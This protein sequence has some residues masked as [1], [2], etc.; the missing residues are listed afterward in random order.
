MKK[1]VIFGI[2]G[3]IGSYI[4]EML[5]ER[6]Y[7]VYGIIRR[8]SSFNTPRIDHIF[9]KLHLYYGDITDYISIDKVL[10]EVKPDYI[11]NMA[12]QSHVWISFFQPLYTSQVDGIGPL[13]ILESMKVNCPKAKYVQAST[14]ELYG[15]LRNPGQAQTEDE[16]LFNPISPYAAAKLYGYYITK[17]YRESYGL[18]ACNSICFNNEGPRRGG[19]FVTKKITESLVKISSGKQKVL[20]LGNIDSLRDWGY[21]KEYA[22]GIIKIIENEYP[23]DYVLATNETHSIREFV[24]EAARYV[25]YDIEW[26]GKGLEE[27]GIDKNSGKV[28]VEIDPKYFRPAE[29]DVLLGDYTKAKNELGWEPKVKFKELVKIMMEHDISTGGTSV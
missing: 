3:Q 19:N 11:F 25:G 18:F 8:S 28:I 10:R 14:S 21:S 1:V 5:L 13:L 4:A 17:I 22:E 12:A 23:S 16:L 15:K 2:T 20:K 9:D 29:V 24:E 26:Y 6:G 7:E 27:K